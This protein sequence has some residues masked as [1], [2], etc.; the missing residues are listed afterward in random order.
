[1]QCLSLSLEDTEYKCIKYKTCSINVD[2]RM[3]TGYCEYIKHVRFANQELILDFSTDKKRSNNV[4]SLV[5]RL[6]AANTP[7]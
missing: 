3:S 4:S 6:R 5:S 7:E 1:M 2:E